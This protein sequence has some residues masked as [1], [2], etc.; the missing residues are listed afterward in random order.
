VSILQASQK[1]SVF[2]E[3][4]LWAHRTWRYMGDIFYQF[5]F[6]KFYNIFQNHL[7][8]KHMLVGKALR[9]QSISLVLH[10]AL[11]MQWSWANIDPLVLQPYKCNQ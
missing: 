4:I 11:T 8:K 10:S 3:T 6:F 5:F 1:L 7:R 2:G 9:P